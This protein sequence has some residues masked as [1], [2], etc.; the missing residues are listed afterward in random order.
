MCEKISSLGST[1]NVMARS[2]SV[3]SVTI[4]SI[5][6]VCIAAVEPA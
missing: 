6:Q 3:I 5:D 1:E 4:F 2:L